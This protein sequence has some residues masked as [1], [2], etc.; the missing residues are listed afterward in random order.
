MKRMTLLARKHGTSTSD[1]RGYWAGPHARLALGMQGISRYVHNRVDKILWSAGAA[2][3]FDIDGIVELSF[4]DAAA[5][6]AAQASAVGRSY[7]PADE[8]NF[9]RGWTLCLVDSEGE[10]PA[11]GATKVLI[12]FHAAQEARAGLWSALRGAGGPAVALGLNWTASTA[13]RERLWSE[14]SPPTGI[15][16]AWF[17]GVVEAHDAFEPSSPLRQALAARTEDASAYLIDELR[18]R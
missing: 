5:M 10:E 9:L 17:P 8:P 15:V 16:A 18:I 14:P 13:R 12:P 2:P 4:L 3:A 11:G 1:F 7:I 6:Q